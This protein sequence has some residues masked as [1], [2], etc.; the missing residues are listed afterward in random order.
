MHRGEG[1]N[2]WYGQLFKQIEANPDLKKL[3]V[4]EQ[5]FSENYQGDFSVDDA[6]PDLEVLATINT[7]DPAISGIDLPYEYNHAAHAAGLDESQ[8]AQA[9][10]NALEIAFL[11]A[12]EKGA[13]IATKN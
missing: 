6:I 13:L 3:K 4:S 9:Q 7:D 2:K 11:S 10:R 5:T 8:I 1:M 12:E